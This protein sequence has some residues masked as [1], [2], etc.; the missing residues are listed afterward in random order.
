MKKGLS[1]GLFLLLDLTILLTAH[2]FFSLLDGKTQAPKQ[3]EVLGATVQAT[4]PKLTK[5]PETHDAVII[6][7]DARGPLI[8]SFLTKYNSPMRGLGD[9][10]VQQADANDLPFWLVPA[11]AQCE[12]NLG[13]RTPE[14]SN[15]AWGWGIYGDKITKFKSWEEGIEKVSKGLSKDY[16]NKGFDTPAEIMT[17]YTPSSNGSWADC[18]EQFLRELK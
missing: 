3:G 11:I 16:M 7:S 10:V 18:V 9:K 12:S 1:L 6:S 5:E 2:T 15:N 14:G 8:E 17:K 13:K 4:Y